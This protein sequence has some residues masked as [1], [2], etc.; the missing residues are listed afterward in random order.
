MRT[1]R[2][3]HQKQTPLGSCQRGQS[4]SITQGFKLATL[5]L[6]D[7]KSKILPLSY[8]YTFTY[9]SKILAVEPNWYYD[10]SK[11][12][13]CKLVLKLSL[14]KSQTYFAWIP[15]W[16]N[17]F[18]LSDSL[19]EES[20]T[21]VQSGHVHIVRIVISIGLTVPLLFIRI[22]S[23]ALSKTSHHVSCQLNNS[24]KERQ[25][26]NMEFCA[27]SFFRVVAFGKHRI[28]Q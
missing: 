1:G 7:V 27:F 15:A 28:T 20:V 17:K 2:T 19:Q 8:N 5:D 25:E 14:V 12:S 23:V 24:R 13:F 3:A 18:D 22:C 26:Y 6:T 10:S 4:C 21:C 16:L 11:L 9:W